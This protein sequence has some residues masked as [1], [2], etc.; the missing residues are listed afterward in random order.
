MLHENDHLPDLELDTDCHGKI[1]LKD[2]LGKYLVLYFYPKDDTPGCTL[3]AKDFSKLY[4]EFK[5]LNC[6]VIGISRD[7]L[8]KHKKFKDKYSLSHVLGTADDEK[9]YQSFG[10]LSE[11]S[12]FGVKYIGLDRST[13]L[14]NPQGM[15]IKIWYKVKVL[16]HAEEVYQ[17]L[18][19]L[20]N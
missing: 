16:G 11:K 1:L 9:F 7:N 2:Y 17:V 3:E 14:I 5:A 10:A 18:K 4:E 20:N 15:I 6:E 13:F 19:S 8:N 12:M